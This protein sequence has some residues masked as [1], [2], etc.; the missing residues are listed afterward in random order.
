MHATLGAA[1]RVPR[2]VR[3]TKFAQPS[4]MEHFHMRNLMLAAAAALSLSAVP[5]AVAAQA[6]PGGPEAA[7]ATYTMTDV[8]HALY[9]K[10]REDRRIA[11]DAWTPELQQFFWA[12]EPQQQRGWWVLTPAQRTMVTQMT[13]E[14]RAKAFESVVAQLNASEGLSPAE[15]AKK[16]A[17]AKG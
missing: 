1:L 4:R 16:A 7:T 15:A 14:N 6:L 2:W 11:Y 9:S 5:T 13:P 8:Q 12:L 17:P 10:W 3:F